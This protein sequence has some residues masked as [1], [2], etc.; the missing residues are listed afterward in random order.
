MIIISDTE[1][2]KS[3]ETIDIVKK[4]FHRIFTTLSKEVKQKFMDLNL[5]KDELKEV[6]K[7]L[8][9]LPEDKQLEYLEELKKDN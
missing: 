1:K 8:A 2:D 6:K 7:S 4:Y 3:F 5:T 9:F